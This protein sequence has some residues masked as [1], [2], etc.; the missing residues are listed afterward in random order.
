MRRGLVEPRCRV[1][2]VRRMSRVERHEDL[3][4]HVLG[5]ADVTGDAIGDADDARVLRAEEPF[6]RFTHQAPRR[7]E[8]WQSRDVTAVRPGARRLS[9]SRGS[10]GTSL[11]WQ[12]Y[13]M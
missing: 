12:T 2:R 3:L 10:N 9:T 7:R 13:E 6:E 11:A 4:G 8:M 1:R 5:L